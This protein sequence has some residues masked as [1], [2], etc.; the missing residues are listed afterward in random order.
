MKNLAK[1]FAQSLWRLTLPVRVP[2]SRKASA[3]IQ[4]SAEQALRDSAQP[5]LGELL[6]G[7]AIARREVGTYRNETNL[8]LD[9]LVREMT[10]LQD[11]IASLRAELATNDGPTTLPIL[12]PTASGRDL[13]E[14]A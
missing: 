3:L 7:V 5:Q 9:S 6:V 13:A 2:I 8:L 12:T 14:S 11:D 4:R 10:R 1:R